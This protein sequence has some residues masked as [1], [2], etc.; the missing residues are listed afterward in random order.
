MLAAG[1]VDQLGDGMVRMRT[2]QDKL[3]KDNSP[4]LIAPNASTADVR[5]NISIR[6]RFG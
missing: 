2:W 6:G 1:K 5:N 3:C 4:T